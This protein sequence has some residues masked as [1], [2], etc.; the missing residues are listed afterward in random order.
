M[1]EKF[2]LINWLA[3][4]IA[5]LGSFF[6]GGFW[7]QAMFG[8][9]WVQMHGWSETEVN[10]MKAKMKPVVFFVG[11]V[12]SYLVAAVGM[13]FVVVNLSINQWTDGLILGAVIWVIVASAAFTNHIAVQKR[14]AVFAIDAGFFL[15]FLLF[16]GAL[17]AYWR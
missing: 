12:A 9:L 7:Y 3:V 11:M 16:Q 1:L 5:G 10:E 17:L 15:V 8:N 13:A 4:L 6:L 14:S 2:A